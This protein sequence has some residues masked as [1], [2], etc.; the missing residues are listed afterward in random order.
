M[1][2]RARPHHDLHVRRG[3]LPGCHDLPRRK[4][5]LDPLRSGRP[6]LPRNT[7]EDERRLSVANGDEGRARRTPR[8]LSS[9]STSASPMEAGDVRH[10]ASPGRTRRLEGRR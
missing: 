7:D 4:R 9:S 6:Q 8:T 1:I 10:R 2:R 5:R 3:Q